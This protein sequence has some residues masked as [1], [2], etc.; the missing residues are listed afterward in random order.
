MTNNHLFATLNSTALG[1][2]HLERLFVTHNDR[3][4]T[5]GA[6][7]L[8]SSLV[9]I[10]VP[11]STESGGAFKQ[12]L[13]FVSWQK[14]YKGLIDDGHFP[15]SH[16]W[17]N[18][19]PGLAAFLERT[20]GNGWLDTLI[21]KIQGDHALAEVPDINNDRDDDKSM[22]RI[23]TKATAT[24]YHNI[25]RIFGPSEDR[26]VALWTKSG[27]G[28]KKKIGIVWKSNAKRYK[29]LQIDKG[30]KFPAGVKK[31]AD[32]EQS[33]LYDS[34]GLGNSTN[35]DQPRKRGTLTPQLTCRVSCLNSKTRTNGF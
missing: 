31:W 11:T 28:G 23:S 15:I 35:F 1:I 30:A 6:Y 3:D 2:K 16:I 9:D 19:K 17:F 10:S 27:V 12:Y 32:L 8:L 7:A 22:V 33:M 34:K 24:K 18:D 13:K 26:L 5:Y 20:S 14:G 4:H 29:V 21:K 25:P